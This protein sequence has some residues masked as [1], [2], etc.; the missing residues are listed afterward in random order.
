ME[1]HEP[2]LPGKMYHVYNRGNNRENLFLDDWTY[3]F[4]LKR[5]VHYISTVADTFAY[6]LEPNHFHFFVRIRP[7]LDTE[8]RIHSTDP[9]RR[10]SH[11]FNSYARTFNL[12]HHRSGVL[13]KTPFRRKRVRS[14]RQALT[15]L[16][17][18]HRNPSNHGVADFT[19]WK[20]SS[21]GEILSGESSI[22][23][24][25]EV[26]SW[27]DSLPAYIELHTKSRLSDR[28]KRRISQ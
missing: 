22:V 21:Y 27:F 7:W 2:L 24:V 26:R 5:Y 20:Y 19:E 4:F 15:L 28:L 3:S 6:C 23:H 16:R 25:A 17:Y 12:T 13:F 8:P 18:I 11:L 1:F 14:H 10:F 9:S